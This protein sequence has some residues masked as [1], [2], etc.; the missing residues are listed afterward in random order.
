MIRL[1]PILIVFMF[2]F[3][4]PI[5]SFLL[6]GIRIGDVKPDLGLI[7]AYGIGFTWGGTKGLLFGLIF[8]GLQ[9]FFSVGR[10]GL[11][12][13]LK[14]LVGFGT[15]LLEIVVIHFPLQTHFVFM[16]M[17]S[18]LH[19]MSGEFFLHGMAYDLVSE[20]FYLVGRGLYNGIL[21]V[22]LLL[23]LSKQTTSK[24]SWMESI[25]R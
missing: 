18:L 10:L 16:F 12:C 8:G 6:E 14:G 2:V 7:L 19:D 4:V 24:S 25:L 1:Y 9:D 17:I 5:Q 3:F 11:H 20:S 22:V 13:I 23:F 21:A 15:G